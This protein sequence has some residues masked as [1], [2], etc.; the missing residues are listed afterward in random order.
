MTLL[1]S[2][3]RTWIYQHCHHIRSPVTESQSTPHTNTH[4]I[5]KYVQINYMLASKSHTRKYTLPAS[6]YERSSSGRRIKLKLVFL[7]EYSFMLS[8]RLVGAQ[9]QQQKRDST[10]SPSSLILLM[11]PLCF[12]TLIFACQPDKSVSVANAIQLSLH[13]RT[14][15]HTHIHILIWIVLINCLFTPP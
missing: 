2:C 9:Q 8:T 3:H 5:H 1:I 11:L 7:C 4:T 10:F 14:N 6:H 15:T 12:R 13:A